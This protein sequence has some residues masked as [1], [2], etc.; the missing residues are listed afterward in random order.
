MDKSRDAN[1][2]GVSRRII[3]LLRLFADSEENLSIQEISA[4]L[5]FAPS[6]VHRLLAGLVEENLL[7][8]TARRRYCVGREFARIGALAA[9]KISTPRLARPMLNDLITRTGETSMLL[10][11][12]PRS[13]ELTVV[14]KIECVH[15]LRFKVP[16][17]SGRPLLWGAIGRA[18]LAWMDTDEI[19]KV[20]ASSTNAPGG[21]DPPPVMSR[22]RSDLDQI[23]SAGYAISRGEIIQGAIDIAAP[24]FDANDRVVGN[25]AITIPEVRFRNRDEQRL[26]RV[27]MDNAGALSAA[28]GYP[29][30]P[31]ARKKLS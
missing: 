1:Q 24:V 2:I 8:R 25:L 22:L 12:L 26:S 4:R 30:S 19:A 27:V 13:K 6:S 29:G 9:R 31:T 18:V 20:H 5:D 14:D 23:R 3:A 7:E 17:N 28:L 16:L 11:M 10:M 15:P 21:G